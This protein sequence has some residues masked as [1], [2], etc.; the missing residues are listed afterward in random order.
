MM[1]SPIT[2]RIAFWPYWLFIYAEG[3][4]G[5][6]LVLFLL[7]GNKIDW[8]A[9]W[10]IL[11]IMIGLSAVATWGMHWFY[12]FRITNTEIKGFNSLG[13]P[14]V[15]LWKEVT[16]M[17][18]INLLGL[19]YLRIYSQGRYWALWFPLQIA[20]GPSTTEKLVELGEQPQRLLIYFKNS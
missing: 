3:A 19:K 5:F 15:F 4:I 6:T 7:H 9:Y 8:P 2:V 11:G 13:L 17:K 20:D 18:P 1:L 16:E 12:V 14:T 10:V